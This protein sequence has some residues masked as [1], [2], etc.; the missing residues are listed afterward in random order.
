VSV[1]DGALRFLLSYDAVSTVIPGTRSVAHLMS[2][3]A[4]ADGALPQDSVDAIRACTP[5]PSPALRWT[6]EPQPELR[7]NLR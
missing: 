5:A 4:A 6:G 7:S 1:V 2:S 3:V